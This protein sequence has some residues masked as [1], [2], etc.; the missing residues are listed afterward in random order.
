MQWPHVR[1]GRATND[2]Y[3]GRSETGNHRATTTVFP[4]A[5]GG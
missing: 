4:V 2:A 3:D 1:S 5:G